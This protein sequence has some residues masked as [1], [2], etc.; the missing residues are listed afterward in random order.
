M[1]ERETYHH[2]DAETDTMH[3]VHVR[4]SC[5]ELILR[6]AE[7]QISLVC[8]MEMNHFIAEL[9]KL[10]APTRKET[11]CR[12]YFQPHKTRSF[13]LY[14]DGK[15]QLPE[16]HISLSNSAARQMPTYPSATHTSPQVPP[17]ALGRAREGECINRVGDGVVV[18]F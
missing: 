16:D 15:R 6:F 8:M 4:T 5:Q 17:P 9:P 1:N 12:M 3:K 14:R 13:A 18:L 7:E 10:N 11:G 2:E